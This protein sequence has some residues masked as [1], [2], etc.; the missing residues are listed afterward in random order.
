MRERHRRS[1]PVPPVSGG[2]KVAAAAKRHCA[3]RAAPARSPT[4]VFVGLRPLLQSPAPCSR[5]LLLYPPS[6]RLLSCVSA[7]LR[8]RRQTLFLVDASA[9][10]S[11]FPVWD[12]PEDEPEAAGAHGDDGEGVGAG[13]GGKK[14]KGGGAAAAE[15]GEP[16][17]KGKGKKK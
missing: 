4:H 17:K 5:I 3:V 10:L 16:A 7:C 15:G 2:A 14:R 12:P 1:P 13:A 11:G 8:V 9:D 6:Y